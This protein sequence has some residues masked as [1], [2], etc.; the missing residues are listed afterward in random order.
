M[1]LEKTF[2]FKLLNTKIKRFKSD[3]CLLGM[4]TC[5]IYYFIAIAKSMF[6]HAESPCLGETAQCAQI[7]NSSEQFLAHERKY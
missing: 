2:I 1:V 5:K 6:E 7:Q 3:L 4:Y